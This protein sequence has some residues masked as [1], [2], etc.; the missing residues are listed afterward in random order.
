MEEPDW[1]QVFSDEL[2]ILGAREHWRR[3]NVELREREIFA[4]VNEP[5]VQRL[6]MAYITF[7][8]A[9]KQVA[10]HGAV[11]KPRKGNP[12]AI[13]RISP[14]WAVMRQASADALALEAELGLSPRQ[15]RKATPVQKKIR[16][17]RAADEY[18]KVIK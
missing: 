1:T 16:R 2:D 18:L 9:A 3:L 15:R 4:E 17:A 8:R 7:D 6:V 14:H 11:L 13:P 12:K 10:E 5:A